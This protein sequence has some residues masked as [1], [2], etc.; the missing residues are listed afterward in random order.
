MKKRSRRNLGRHKPVLKKQRRDTIRSASVD[1]LTWD[2][3]GLMCD[4]LAHAL[5][6]LKVATQG[7]IRKYSLGPRGAW[8]L[9]LISGGV[10]LPMD[11][12]VVLRTS[13]ALIAIELS[14]MTKAR[15]VVAK[16]GAKDRRRS[17]LALTALGK[18]A[19]QQVRNEMARII[20]RNLRGY[21]VDEF[22]LVARALR[23][24]RK[25]EDGDGQ[26]ID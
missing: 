13:R 4:G 8:I 12:A 17:E 16:P 2:D 14:R 25:I 24:V 6:P 26:S 23:D 21:S 10:R 9:S 7:I 22:R 5:L 3:I 1:D 15:L 11:L 20:R 19:C 18:A